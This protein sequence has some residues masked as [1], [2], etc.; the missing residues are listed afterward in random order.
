MVGGGGGSE[1]VVISQL[2]LIFIISVRTRIS[3]IQ[4]NLQSTVRVIRAGLL[5]HILFV[6][7][8]R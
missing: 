7:M 2:W 5:A 6:S 1:S 3:F 4:G 8:E